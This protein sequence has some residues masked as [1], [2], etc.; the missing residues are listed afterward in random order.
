MSN[1]VIMIIAPV[2]DPFVPRLLQAYNMALCFM[3]LLKKKPLSS[4][5]WDRS[6]RTFSKC[7]DIRSGD[8]ELNFN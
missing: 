1:D 3:K 8:G 5:V 7:E 2:S 6:I 4:S